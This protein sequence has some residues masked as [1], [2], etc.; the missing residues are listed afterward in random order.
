MAEAVRRRRR[1]RSATGSIRRPRHQAT[2]DFV[3]ARP[4]YTLSAQAGARGRV[5]DIEPNWGAFGGSF[6]NPGYAVVN[7]GVAVRLVRGVELLARVNNLFDRSV[8]GGLRLPRAGT[9]GDHRGARCCGPMT[10]GTPTT[11]SRRRTV[12]RRRGSSPGR[13]VQAPASSE[14]PVAGVAARLAAG[15]PRQPLRHSRRERIRARRRCFGSS[16]GRS[17]PRAG[18][19]SLDGTDL[20][21]F[22]RRQ[23]ARR[24]AVVPQETHLAFDYSVLEIALMGRYPH[25]GPFALEGL[26][27]VAIARDALAATGTASARGPGRSPR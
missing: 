22:S 13:A 9:R 24:I 19:V 4:R 10:S 8:R 16:A 1:S 5:L 12:P 26:R 25:L 15:Q 20:S 21:R 18:G 7:A 27:D 2:L 17:G 11:A 3:L 23:L 6:G 14:G